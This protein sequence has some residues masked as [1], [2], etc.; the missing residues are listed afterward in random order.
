MEIKLVTWISLLNQQEAVK[1][2]INKHCWHTDQTTERTKK[3]NLGSTDESQYLGSNHLILAQNIQL[4]PPVSAPHWY[5]PVQHLQCKV[6][7]SYTSL[8][9][10]M[11]QPS[12]TWHINQKTPY[13]QMTSLQHTTQQMICPL[14]DCIQESAAIN[15]QINTSQ[16]IWLIIF[17]KSI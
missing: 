5:Q 1:Y 14:T 10:H 15:T 7:P 16:V 2:M 3:T 11:L 13:N 9:T 8:N 4:C 17:R 12:H 6:L